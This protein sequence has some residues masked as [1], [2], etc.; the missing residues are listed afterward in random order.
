MDFGKF[1]TP[2]G[3]EV[4]ESKDNFNYSR[5]LL[6]ALAIPYYHMGARI[7]YAVNDKVS[8]TGFLVNGWND[9]M[10][11]NSA[12]TVGGSVSL[13][14]EREVGA[15]RELPGRQGAAPRRDGGTRNLVD[16][17]FSYAANG[18]TS[19]LFNYDYGHDNVTTT[20]P[21]DER[22]TTAS[23]GRASRSA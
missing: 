2:A 13:Q 1:V 20:G 15:D 3:A 18:K 23:R 7:G 21:A 5:G 12:K 8:L 16:V 4:I 10:D 14:A 11:N 17:V 9:V 19:L 6:F 22:C